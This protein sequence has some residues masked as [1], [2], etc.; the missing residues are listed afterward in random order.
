MINESF[1]LCT[2]PLHIAWCVPLT[3]FPIEMPLL[4]DRWS[5]HRLRHSAGP[6]AGVIAGQQTVP[7][8]T[9]VPWPIDVH[10]GRDCLL[11]FESGAPDHSGT[12]K[13]QKRRRHPEPDRHRRPHR[14]DPSIDTGE[15]RLEC[16]VRPTARHVSLAPRSSAPPKRLPRR[17]MLAPVATPDNGRPCAS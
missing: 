9:S 14:V 10:S 13:R 6:R 15:L 12:E 16:L 8:W 4:V 7:A 2:R 5:R 3:P 17:R 1:L 11:P